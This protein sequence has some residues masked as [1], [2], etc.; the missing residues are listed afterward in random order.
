MKDKNLWQAFYSHTTRNINLKNKQQRFKRRTVVTVRVDGCNLYIPISSVHQCQRKRSG[1]LL[2]T[3][4]PW[5][6]LQYFD[7]FKWRLEITPHKD[8]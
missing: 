7:M 4:E 5:A 8:E 3:K 1:K 2:Q 6:L